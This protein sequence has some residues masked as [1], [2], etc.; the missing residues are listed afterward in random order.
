MA[1]DQLNLFSGWA[2]AVAGMELSY[3]A[4]TDE[5]KAA[6]L[7]AAHQT[8]LDLDYLIADDVWVRFPEGFDTWD[9]N[10]LGHVMRQA[11]ANGWIA[12]TGQTRASHRAATHCRPQRIWR[13]MLRSDYHA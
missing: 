3:E 5:W 1:D 13:S 11:K 10:A 7:G 9:G 2:L 6:A 4:Q 8:A 12:S